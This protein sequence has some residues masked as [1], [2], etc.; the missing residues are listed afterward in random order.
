[1]LLETLLRSAVSDQFQPPLTLEQRT[2]SSR[3]GELD[4][5]RRERCRF[6]QAPANAAG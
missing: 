5:E 1:M 3:P 2:G 4:T 6:L